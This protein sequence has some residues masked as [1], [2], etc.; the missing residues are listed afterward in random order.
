MADEKAA[1]IKP[2]LHWMGS[3][4]H[5]VVIWQQQLVENIGRNGAIVCTNGSEN[6]GKRNG[7]CLSARDR[8]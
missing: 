4:E 6:C 1:S 3:V 5:G 2:S 8:N 7:W